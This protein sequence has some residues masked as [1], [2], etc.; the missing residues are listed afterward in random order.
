MTDSEAQWRLHM[1]G[2]LFCDQIRAIYA[3]LDENYR[4]ILLPSIDAWCT[5]NASAVSAY[6]ELNRSEE[7]D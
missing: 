2:P 1:A 7:H 4:N 3:I 5:A 6:V